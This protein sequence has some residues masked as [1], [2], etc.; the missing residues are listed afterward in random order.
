MLAVYSAL[1]VTALELLSPTLS[2]LGDALPEALTALAGVLKMLA[3]LLVLGLLGI[4]ALLLSQTLA[5]PFTARSRGERNGSHRGNQRAAGGC[6]GEVGAASTRE[7]RSYAELAA[8]RRALRCEPRFLA[9]GLSGSP[10]LLLGAWMLAGQFLDFT[11]ENR[12]QRFH[13][14]HWR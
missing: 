9:W 6:G 13:Q 3:W 4:L 7:R 12:G 1:V 8:P 11:Q 5:A 14:K 2:G 10:T